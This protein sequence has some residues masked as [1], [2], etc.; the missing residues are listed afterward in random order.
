MTKPR[1]NVKK[2]RDESGWIG[3]PSDTYVKTTAAPGA[4]FQIANMELLASEHK[5]RDTFHAYLIEGDEYW[6]IGVARRNTKLL[7]EGVA[8]FP[9]SMAG[10]AQLRFDE[11]ESD[12]DVEDLMRE[13]GGEKLT[14]EFE[15][16]V[17]HG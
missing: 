7:W 13:W 9:A 3:S 6:Y 17:I 1:E 5:E 12:I 10:L 15:E 4:R 2:L 8:G 14:A 11:L 16:F